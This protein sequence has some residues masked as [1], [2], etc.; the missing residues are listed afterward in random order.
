MDLTTHFQAF[1][2]IWVVKHQSWKQW[3]FAAIQLKRLNLSPKFLH[4]SLIWVS[5][6]CSRNSMHLLSIPLVSFFIFT[7]LISAPKW[8]DIFR[9]AEPQN[10]CVELIISH[11]SALKSIKNSFERVPKLCRLDLSNNHL[12]TINHNWVNWSQLNHG[13]N[14]QGNPI[15]CTCKSQWML[16]YFVPMLYK[17]KETQHYLLDLRCTTPDAFK[18]HRLVRY[19]NNTDV[20]CRPGVIFFH[21]SPQI[22]PSLHSKIVLLFT[23]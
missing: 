17:H 1:H 12:Q 9:L 18:G 8:Y 10:G 7:W 21:W 5:Y 14:L 2:H 19:M 15:D 20:F 23:F 11:N 16:D 13:V 4:I 6:H 22:E 3:I